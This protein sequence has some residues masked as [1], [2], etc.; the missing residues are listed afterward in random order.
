[1]TTRKRSIKISGH[2]TSVSLEDDFWDEL[3]DIAAQRKISL[4]LL[5]SEIDSQA[6]NADNLSSSLRLYVLRTLKSR[7]IAKTP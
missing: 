4:N 7:L 5:I 2:D 6:I 1:M 3:K